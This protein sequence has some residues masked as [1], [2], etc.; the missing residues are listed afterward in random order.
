M[1]TELAK[2]VAEVFQERKELGTLRHWLMELAYQDIKKEL[3]QS[4]TPKPS[5][6]VAKPVAKPKAERT[7]MQWPKQSAVRQPSVQQ[8]VQASAQQPRR[9]APQQ[10]QQPSFRQN[11]S[12]EQKF[13]SDLALVKAYE[14]EW[15]DLME[16]GLR[17]Y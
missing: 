7:P 12:P 10:P 14:D 11:P 1:T 4:A 2:R 9:P 16:N 3:G 8:P 6:P 15:D 13:E 17:D 5:K